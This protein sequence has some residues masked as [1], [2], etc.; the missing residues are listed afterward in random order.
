MSE[1]LRHLTFTG[2]CI[3]ILRSNITE[4]YQI[5]KKSITLMCLRSIKLQKPLILGK[6]LQNLGYKNT[7]IPRLFKVKTQNRREIH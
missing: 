4:T 2:I 6:E 1:R 7:Q 5:N 3:E